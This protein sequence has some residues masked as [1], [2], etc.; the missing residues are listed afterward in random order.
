MNPSE[1]E[2]DRRDFL[3]QSALGAAAAAAA[4]LT[5]AST[6]H[7]SAQT[8]PAAAEPEITNDVD[9]LVVGGGTAGHDRGNPGWPGR[10]Q[11]PDPGTQQPAWRHD[12]DRWCR[13]PRFV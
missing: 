4:G 7:V 8:D 3:Q 10:R 11:D 1:T 2:T 12:D 6:S 5:I 9:V 13:L